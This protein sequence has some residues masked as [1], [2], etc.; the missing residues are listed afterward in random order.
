MEED[1]TGKSKSLVS[2]LVEARLEGAIDAAQ[3]K[4]DYKSAHDPELLEAIQVVEAFLRKKQR[5]CYGGTAMNMILP[6]SKQFYDLNYEIPDYD[7]FT[8][9]LEED[10]VELVKMLKEA[11]FSDIYHRVGI[12]K[13]TKKILVNFIPIADITYISP[14]EYSVFLKRSIVREGLHYTDPD[15]LRMM[16]YLELS[17]PSGQVGRWLKVYERLE[18]LNTE[19]PVKIPKG[20]C[21]TS[22]SK[23]KMTRRKGRK[24]VT[25]VRSLL[26]NFVIESQRILVNGPLIDVYE[27]GILQG[28]STLKLLPGGCVTFVSPTPRRDVKILLESIPKSRQLKVLKHA[29]VGEIV[30]ERLE[31]VEHGTPIC[32]IIQDMACHSYYPITFED[33]R[34]ILIGSLEFLITLYSSLGFFTKRSQRFFDGISPLCH[35]KKLIHF[36]RLNA[37]TKSSQ[38]P[39]FT[40]L[41]KGHQKG[42]VSLLREK[43]QRLKEEKDASAA[44]PEEKY[45]SR[46]LTRKKSKK[47]TKRDAT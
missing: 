36:A 18:L 31:I 23:E 8:P 22:F 34:T 11:G 26:Y 33:G 37:R 16:M 12:H 32:L 46:S 40:T 14:A 47:G 42:F 21:K 27:R 30:P 13:G 20:L 43:V 44:Y 7:F 35:L 6:P 38:F 10:T 28:N 25:D 3:K 2:A 39:A 5:V 1:I 29:A 4:Q 41:C 9:E 15:L 19:F 17:R 24:S 45:S